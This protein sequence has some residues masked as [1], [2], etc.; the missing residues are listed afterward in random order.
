MAAY[1]LL[2]RVSEA[3]LLCFDIWVVGSGMMVFAV[4]AT[5]LVLNFGLKSQLA[6][7]VAGLTS[8]LG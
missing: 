8:R 2:L 4:L 6:A 5:S 7:T 3:V 1:E